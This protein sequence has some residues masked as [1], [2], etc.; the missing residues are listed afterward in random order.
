M[1]TKELIAVKTAEIDEQIR[2][3]GLKQWWIAQTLTK[4]VHDPELPN[5]KQLVIT[6]SGFTKRKK[7][8]M[9]FEDKLVGPLAEI[10]GV[11]P[12]WI[13]DKFALDDNHN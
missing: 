7:G 5:D 12:D 4:K 10:L 13:R 9:A 2:Y 3:R 8:K 11:S 6:E 1:S